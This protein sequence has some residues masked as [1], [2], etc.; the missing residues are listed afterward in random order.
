MSQS[1][2]L[3]EEGP[4]LPL[5]GTLA[6][7]TVGHVSCCDPVPRESLTASPNLPSGNTCLFFFLHSKCLDRIS[8]GIWGYVQVGARDPTQML[9]A[10][11]EGGVALPVPLGAFGGTNP[12]Q[13]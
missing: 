8:W 3:H 7:T 13:S 4:W 2:H 12:L 10:G 11:W 5:P 6:T 1:I 9:S